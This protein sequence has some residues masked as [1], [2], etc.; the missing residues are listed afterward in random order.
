[1]LEQVHSIEQDRGHDN[2]QTVGL[3]SGAEEGAPASGAVVELPGPVARHTTG[4]APVYATAPRLHDCYR[5]IGPQ[6]MRALLASSGATR[7][8]ERNG[9]TVLVPTTM[10]VSGGIVA[11]CEGKALWHVE[12]LAQWLASM[13]GPRL[14]RQWANQQVKQPGPG[15]DGYVSATDL[16]RLFN[17]GG[18]RVGEWLT[19]IGL[20]GPDG[21]PTK[22]AVKSG[23]A[24]TAEMNSVGDSGKKVARKFGLWAMVPIQE[25]LMAAGHPL[26]MDYSATL[27]GK[28]RNSDVEVGS[29][30]GELDAAQRRIAAAA[31]ARDAGAL[32]AAVAAVDPKYHRALEMRLKR[33]GL[34][35]RDRWRKLAESWG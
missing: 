32:R 10:A 22:V 5:G 25:R 24:R 2:S 13:G 27:K 20:R 18:A 34:L 15:S 19:G 14:E 31:R 33:P 28:G 29:A 30:A 11:K 8:A 16:G 12:R 26:D 23:L 4:K 21:L 17:V 35:T 7:E 3:R 6:A 9:R 1:M